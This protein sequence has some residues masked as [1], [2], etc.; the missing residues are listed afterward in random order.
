MDHMCDTLENGKWFR[1]LN[2]IDDNNREALIVKPKIKF[3]CEH[4]IRELDN[5]DFYRSKPKS[6]R[7]DNGPEFMA[8][9]F[10]EWCRDHNIQI[11]YIQPGKP[12]QNAFIERFN[13]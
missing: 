2:V 6:I 4:V 5:L 13:R 7:V 10:V 11:K 12:Q 8:R 1:I 3:P 9:T